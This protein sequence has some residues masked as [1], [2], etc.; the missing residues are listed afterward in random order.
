MREFWKKI[1]RFLKNPPVWFLVI[2]YVLAVASI[3][4]ALGLLFVDYVGT[5][6]E[7]VA[8]AVFALAAITLAYV[9]FTIIPLVPKI[10]AWLLRTLEK[11]EFTRAIRHN[12]GHRTIIFAI[13]T[14]F[15]SVVYG[16]FNGYLG[17]VGQSIWYGALA[18]YYIFLAFI[19]GGVLAYHGKKHAG[20]LE[21]ENDDLE[22]AKTYRNSGILLLIVN[23]A[24]SAAIA[25]MIFDDRFFSYADW[26]IF[27]SAAY[28]FYKIT[29]SIINLFK[30]RKQEDLTIE[31]IRNINLMDATVSILALQTALLHTFQDGT[32]DVSLFNTLT[33]SAV[34][35][36]TLALGV[37]MILKATKKIK[38]IRMENAN[39][40]QG[41]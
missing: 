32:V 6:L 38:E 27:A 9:V 35:V 21:R 8:Y 2:A 23:T 10:K 14:F 12:Y 40:E 39:G 41:V 18:A 17:L 3:A 22:K 29:M 31:A 36:F 7:I 16:V 11:Y 30:A 15:M 4:G 13:G 25:Q 34:S 5:F 26:T 28:A 20:R 33:G 24:L 37:Y 19:R 1:W